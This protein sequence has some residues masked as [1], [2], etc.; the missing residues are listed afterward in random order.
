MARGAIFNHAAQIGT[1]CA[2][3]AY[4]AVTSRLLDPHLFGVL[5]A[6]LT[7]AALISLL[8]VAGLPQII[9]RMAVLDANRLVGLLTYAV[10]VGLAGAL[11]LAATSELWAT[12]WGVP[13]AG[14]MIRLLAVASFFTPL[15]ALGNGL[16]ARSGRFRTLAAVTLASNVGAMAIGILVVLGARSAESL[17]VAPILSQASIGAAGLILSRSLFSGGRIRWAETQTDLHFSAKSIFASVLIYLS[18][19]VPRVCVSQG[20][21]TS[22]LGNMNR[23]EAITTTP[24]YLFGFSML[25]VIYPEFRHDRG[26]G[27][28]T[29]RVWSD[30]L[31]IVGWLCVPLGAFV[32]VLAPLAVHI[33][34]GDQWNEAA[35]MAR[36]L[37][38]IGSIQPLA[39]VL[40]GGFEAL[41]RFSWLWAG[42]T[43]SIV[44]NVAG[45][46]AALA[47]QSI[48]FIFAGMLLG[49]LTMHVLHL[50]LAVREGLLGFRKVARHYLEIGGCALAIAL[51]TFVATHGVE[52][53]RTAAWLVIVTAVL[54]V[55][56]GAL[57]WRFRAFFPPVRLARAYGLLRR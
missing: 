20:F 18:N 25:Q 29:R 14:S 38:V 7:S 8:A 17:A 50:V 5:A 24:F 53:W 52:L 44:V 51:V 35:N 27:E 46:V 57:L 41:G 10:A 22:T 42:F 4:A 26:S 45:A 48:T 6:S 1:A 55:L 15:V 13:D 28:R 49:H 33:L 19:S 40:V 37:A 39:F 56:G 12:I 36:V 43:V 2:Q 11:L 23:A 47:A 34:F 16:F 21:G 30:L 32:A 3:I 9:G 54:L 31:G